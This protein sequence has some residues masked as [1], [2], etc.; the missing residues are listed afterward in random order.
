MKWWMYNEVEG[1]DDDNGKLTRGE[2]ISITKVMI[3]R[4]NTKSLRPHVIAPVS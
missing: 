1:V 2:I 4:L 3:A